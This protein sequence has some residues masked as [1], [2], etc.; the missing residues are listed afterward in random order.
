MDQGI[1]VEIAMWAGIFFE[2]TGSMGFRKRKRKMLD[3]K[4]IIQAMK[5]LLE[6]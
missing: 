2:Q 6:D 1:P 5:R 3:P 4:Y